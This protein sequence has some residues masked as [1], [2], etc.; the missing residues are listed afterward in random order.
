MLEKTRT[1]SLGIDQ[2]KTRVARK[3]SQ[4]PEKQDQE[5]EWKDKDEP[6]QELQNAKCIVVQMRTSNSVRS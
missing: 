1:E 5:S 2:R 6:R 4:A 3:E